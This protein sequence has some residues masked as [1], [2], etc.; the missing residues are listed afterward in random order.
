[1]PAWRASSLSA[2]LSGWVLI[3]NSAAVG[4]AAWLGSAE[5]AKLSAKI[6]GRS[7]VRREGFINFYS[8]VDDFKNHS[9]VKRM[10]RINPDVAVQIFF[11]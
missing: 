2:W 4:W 1:M 6:K 8:L 11:I 3:L 10:K 7:A 9:Q 5:K